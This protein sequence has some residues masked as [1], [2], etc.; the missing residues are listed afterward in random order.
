MKKIDVKLSDIIKP[1][2]IYSDKGKNGILS[3]IA[4]SE[5]YRGAAYFA[6]MS[7][8][9]CGIGMVQLISTEKVISSVASKVSEAIYIPV[10]EN[11]D[12]AISYF[13]LLNKLKTV[14]KPKAFLIGCGMTDCI[15]TKISLK[16]LVENFENQLIIDA[17]GLN[18]IKSEKEILTKA[19]TAPIIT[20][21]V[22]EMSRLTGKSVSEIKESRISI[23]L[24][25][26][27][28]YNCITVL[29]DFITVVASTQ[30]EYFICEKANSGLAKGGSGD[31]LSGIIASFVAQGYGAF[32]SA[33]CGV[34]L[35]SMAAKLAADKFTE[36]AM[37]PSD[38]IDFI[39]EVFKLL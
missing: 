29:K 16:Y 36:Y 30:G 19:T 20:P 27:K 6:V 14:K 33:V 28:K 25:F 38:V 35:H 24:D 18:S 5:R 13:E 34:L 22:G 21:H 32:D 1:R 31:V 2:D 4:G 39:P 26:S 7:A 8:L 11:S 12:G 37:L 23:A 10:A 3:V 17:D 9:R 15:D